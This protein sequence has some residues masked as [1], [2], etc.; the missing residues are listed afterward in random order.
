MGD[1]QVLPTGGLTLP[2]GPHGH[3]LQDQGGGCQ[4][5][6]SAWGSAVVC[7]SPYDPPTVPSSSLLA[8][9][10]PR[11]SALSVMRWVRRVPLPSSM[12]PPQT[13]GLEEPEYLQQPHDHNDPKGGDL[14]RITT[15]H[16]NDHKL[17][18]NQRCNS[19]MTTQ[20]P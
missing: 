1:A 3:W 20:L 13:V 9:C 14:R 19:R 8:H 7:G 4:A 16:R 17:R 11:L 6:P 15:L 2:A 5:R 12:P 10:P 18:D